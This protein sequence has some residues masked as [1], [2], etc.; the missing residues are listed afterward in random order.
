MRS[1][2]FSLKGGS[3]RP[4]SNQEMKLRLK[5]SSTRLEMILLKKL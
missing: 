4:R 1:K 3:S 5:K 2:N